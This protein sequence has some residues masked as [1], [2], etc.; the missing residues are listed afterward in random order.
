MAVLLVVGWSMD[1]TSCRKFNFPSIVSPTHLLSV[2]SRGEDAVYV[3]STGI[4][5][6]AVTEACCSHPYSNCWSSKVRQNYMYE[7]IQFC[8]ICHLHWFSF[9]TSTKEV[10]FY[11]SL[12]ICLFHII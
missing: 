4:P 6:S 9:V 12:F 3:K 7:Y 5:L 11:L 8:I 10:I 1:S 2:I